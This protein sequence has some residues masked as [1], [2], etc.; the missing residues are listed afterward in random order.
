MERQEVHLYTEIQRLE[1]FVNFVLPD[2][3]LVAMVPKVIIALRLTK[4][5][6]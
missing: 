3:L 1:I 4:T 2:S 5:L 6:L